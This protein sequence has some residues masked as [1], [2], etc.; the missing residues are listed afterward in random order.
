MT[1]LTVSALFFPPKSFLKG[2]IFCIFWRKCFFVFF[3]HYNVLLSTI[4]LCR[5]A[6]DNFFFTHYVCKF[7]KVK[8]KSLLLIFVRKEVGCCSCFKMDLEIPVITVCLNVAIFSSLLHHILAPV[9]V[10]LKLWSVLLTNMFFIIFTY[11]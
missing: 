3:L 11:S 4:T 1:L 6:P 10:I 2:F 5:C 9:L 8:K 7:L